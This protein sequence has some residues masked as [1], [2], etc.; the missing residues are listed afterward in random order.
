MTRRSNARLAGISFLLY[1]VLGIS[2]MIVMGRATRGEGIA[3]ILANAAQHL[4][5]IR[6]AGLLV[7]FSAFC[8]VALGVSLYSVTREQD[9]DLALLGLVFRV[10][11]GIV[12]GVAAQRTLGTAWLVSGG[13]APTG[14]GAQALGSFLLYGSGGPVAAIFFAVGSTLFSWLLLRG[15]MIPPLIAWLG[16]VASLLWV[17]G[18][19]LQILGILRGALTYPLW[20][21]MAAFELPFAVWLIVKGVAPARRA[22]A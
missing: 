6:L 13:N 21:L 19:P 10:G 12:G 1:V 14:E 9:S 16:V 5:E 3:A 22:A 20:I 4:F 17:V 15:R 7:L 2:S 18:M 8:A 11:E